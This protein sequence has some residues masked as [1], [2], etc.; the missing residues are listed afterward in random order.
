MKNIWIGIFNASATCVCPE[1]GFNV[2]RTYYSNNTSIC[3]HPKCLTSTTAL[4]WPQQSWKEVHKPCHTTNFWKLCES[5]IE[6]LI[7]LD[8]HYLRQVEMVFYE[9]IKQSQACIIH[10]VHPD[11]ELE[12]VI[13]L[14][15]MSNSTKDSIVLAVTYT[16]PPIRSNSMPYNSKN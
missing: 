1:M 14:P 11:R 4:T 8:L 12:H 9:P 3:I 10:L 16:K 15:Q 13:S 6:Y 7:H 5:S 2:S